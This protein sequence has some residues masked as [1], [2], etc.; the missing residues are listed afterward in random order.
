MSFIVIE[1][2]DGSGKSTQIELLTK[3][4]DSKQTKFKFVHFP[5]VDSPV[6]GE[7]IAKFLRGDLGALNDVNP[8]LVALLFAGDRFNFA[9]TIR[10][11]INEGYVVI[12]DRYVYS[13]IAFQC[14]KTKS[15]KEAEDL[16]NW[17]LQTEYNYFKIPKPDLSLFLEVPFSFTKQKLTTNRVGEARDYLQGKQDIHE[18]DLDFQLRVKES[19]IK[20]IERDDNFICLKCYEDDKIFKPDYIS[21]L[22]VNKI[23]HLL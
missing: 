11:W 2:L 6:Y 22:I 21:T 18:A 19:Y 13:N 1:G 3:Y 12:T 15:E 10:K 14:A 9:S 5:V 16:F 20:A 7:L 23:K 4:L 17:I 8:Y